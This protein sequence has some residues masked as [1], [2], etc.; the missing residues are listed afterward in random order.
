[1]CQKAYAA[2]FAVTASVAMADVEWTRGERK[3]FQSS[4]AIA[5]GF[6]G[7]CG[8]PLSFEPATGGKNIALSICA[9][10][11]PDALSPQRQSDVEARVAWLHGIEALPVPSAEEIAAQ[12]AK[13]GPRISYQHP[14]HDTETWP[15]R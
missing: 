9:L 4:N 8:T 7:E 2:P 1:M 3:R 12:A 5:R 13:Y 10:D 6:C 11:D 14:D 15:P